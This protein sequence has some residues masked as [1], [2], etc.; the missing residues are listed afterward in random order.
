MPANGGRILCR[1][2]SLSIRLMGSREIPA[3]YLPLRYEVL[4]RELGWAIGDINGPDQLSDDYDRVSIAFGV[5]AGDERLLAAARLIEPAVQ[6]DLP[7]LR[8][9]ARNGQRKR[10]PVPVA[11]LSRLMVAKAYRG[12]GLFLI[13]L[14]TAISL[15][16]H[17]G[18]R[19]LLTTE[20]DEERFAA[21]MARRG[22]KRQ[23][24]GFSFVDDKI[25]PQEPAATYVF[26]LA[27]D[28]GGDMSVMAERDA[29]LYRLNAEF[30]APPI[31]RSPEMNR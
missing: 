7:S 22:F 16:C 5:F 28:L 1:G 31:R 20:R 17:D 3:L 9:L 21:F 18:I 13:L 23:A 24:A 10:F 2:R 26:D 14:L 25:S 8:L 6:D 15:A 12:M 30:D 4:H 11:E 29:L 19:T 27:K